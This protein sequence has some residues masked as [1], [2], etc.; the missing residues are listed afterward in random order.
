M[1]I[2]GLDLMT[3]C[4]LN[5]LVL[6][7]DGVCAAMIDPPHRPRAACFDTK[8]QGQGAERLASWID[9]LPLGATVIVTSCSRLSWAHNREA[10]AE[11]L[12]TLGALD[13]PSR[14]DDAYSLVGVKG[15]TAPLSE[16]RTPCCEN[17][18]PVCHTCDQTVAA[19]NAV[20][21]CGVPVVA[22]ESVLS[23]T[24]YLGTWASP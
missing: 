23:T 10:L 16:A 19:A 12:A 11:A 20:V 6:G 15:A 7:R 14:I 5:K 8:V 4:E 21:A 24:S 22:Q 18:D 17:P 9:E 3:G 1:S 2:N 13:P